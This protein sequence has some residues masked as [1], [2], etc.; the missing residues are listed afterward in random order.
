MGNASSEL[1]PIDIG[2][3]MSGPTVAVV[4]QSRNANFA[5]G[6]RSLP[7]CEGIALSA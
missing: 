1:P 7:G 6:D 4:E 3:P 5:V 2:Q